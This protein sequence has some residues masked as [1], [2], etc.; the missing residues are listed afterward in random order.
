MRNR[1]YKTCEIVGISERYFFCCS[2]PQ[3]IS[4]YP[5]QK[6]QHVGGLYYDNEKQVGTYTAGDR[7]T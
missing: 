3:K 4:D 5:S 1:V 7:I 2:P 6:I